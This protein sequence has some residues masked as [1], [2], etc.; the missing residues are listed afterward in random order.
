M[1]FIKINFMHVVW[2]DYPAMFFL[3]LLLFSSF[4]HG[5]AG[6][7]ASL[8]ATRWRPLRWMPAWTSAAGQSDDGHGCCL[9]GGW[10]KSGKLNGI[11]PGSPP[12]DGSWG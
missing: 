11:Y 1:Y 10:F 12:A 5:W 2:A 3:L 8:T 7:L 4:P 9:K 6:W